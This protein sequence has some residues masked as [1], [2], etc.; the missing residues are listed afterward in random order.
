[1]LPAKPWRSVRGSV[2]FVEPKRARHRL[3]NEAHAER[4]ALVEGWIVDSRVDGEPR[5]VEAAWLFVGDAEPFP[6][7][8]GL[9]RPDV[10]DQLG[11]SRESAGARCGFSQ[12]VRLPRLHGTVECR[13]VA[14][15]DDGAGLIGDRGRTVRLGL[16]PRETP[17]RTSDA[18]LEVVGS[19][20]IRDTVG[21]YTFDRGPHSVRSEGLLIVRGDVAVEGPAYLRLSGAESEYWYDLPRVNPGRGVHG[22]EP[23]AGFWATLAIAELPIGGYRA[24]LLAGDPARPVLELWFE[25]AGHHLYLPEALAHFH[26]AA[27]HEITEFFRAG[28]RPVGSPRAV[29]GGRIAR[30]EPLWIAGWARDPITGGALCD[31][32]ACVNDRVPIPIP[33]RTVNNRTCIEGIIDTSRF[34]AG[35]HRVRLVAVSPIGNGL[36]D[37]GERTFVVEDTAHYAPLAGAATPSGTAPRAEGHRS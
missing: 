37:V 8:L 3:P 6:L 18:P 21:P 12:T 34:E 2:D 24:T 1:M 36:Y 17:V 14:R 19:L 9:P 5:P 31:V 29:D 23:T 22:I 10:A 25:I 28:A 4:E 35:E 7:R 11:M 13:L 33:A 32:Y 20:T 26:Q 16:P 15:A 27:P 30:G